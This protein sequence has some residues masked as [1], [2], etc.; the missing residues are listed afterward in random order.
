MLGQFV[1]CIVGI[2]LVVC[3]AWFLFSRERESEGMNSK[4]FPSFSKQKPN[5]NLSQDRGSSMK[6]ITFHATDQRNNCENF[7]KWNKRN[8]TPYRYILSFP[9]RSMSAVPESKACIKVSVDTRLL[10]QCAKT[11]TF[12]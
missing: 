10:A 8:R 2:I 3:Y 5:I 4:Y 9:Y 11:A 6:Q 7:I 1:F 12:L